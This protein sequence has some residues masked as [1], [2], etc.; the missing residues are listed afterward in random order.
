[1]ALLVES[2]SGPT[3]VKPPGTLN[4]PPCVERPSVRLARPGPQVRPGAAP[5]PSCG[6]TLNS[7]VV[8]CPNGSVLVRLQAKTCGFSPDSSTVVYGVVEHWP[9]EGWGPLEPQAVLQIDLGRSSV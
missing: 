6:E 3:G 7:S 4:E 8:N 2:P 1:M 5:S 9:E